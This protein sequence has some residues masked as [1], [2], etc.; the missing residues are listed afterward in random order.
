MKSYNTNPS[1]WVALENAGICYFNNMEYP[2]AISL[3]EK[4]IGMGV[5]SNGKPEF[6]MGVA[7]VNTGQK[8]KG[9]PLLHIASKKGYKEADAAIQKAC[10]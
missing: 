4:E 3:F 7:L 9:C 6:F 8:E 10:Q 1:N 2:K 5:S